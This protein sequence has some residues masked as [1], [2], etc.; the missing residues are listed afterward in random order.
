VERINVCKATDPAGSFPWT[1]PISNIVGPG[2][3]EFIVKI[4]ISLA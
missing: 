1:L 3:L 2:L 4:S